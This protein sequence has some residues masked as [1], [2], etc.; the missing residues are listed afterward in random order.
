MEKTIFLNAGHDN[1]NDP[2]AIHNTIV[3]SKLNIEVRDRLH[4]YLLKQFK[5]EVVPDKLDLRESII[6]VNNRSS[7]LDDGLAVSI[8]FNTGGG[9]GAEAFYYGGGYAKSELIATTYIN[10]YCSLTG[11]KNRGAKPDTLSNAGQLGWIRQ[12]KPWAVLIECAFIDNKNDMAKF[13]VDKIAYAQ[14][15]GICEIYNIDPLKPIKTSSVEI[16]VSMINKEEIK[17]QI[18]EYI[19]KI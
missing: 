12:T 3:E 5:V 7:N 19:E 1:E 9:E 14:Y 17:K 15:E 18:I 10:K 16:D 2:G 11:Y 4:E 6:W 8:H 13:D